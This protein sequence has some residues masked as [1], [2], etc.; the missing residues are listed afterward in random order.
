MLKKQPQERMQTAF[1]VAHRQ[2]DVE[3]ILEPEDLA[4]QEVRANPRSPP[5]PG[6]ARAL[7][8]RPHAWRLPPTSPPPCRLSAS[9]P[10]AH[11]Q[12]MD[13]QTA[14]AVRLYIFTL[15]PAVQAAMEALV[16]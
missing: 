7:P 12:A 2:L 10:S 6:S 16:A 13:D 14:K 4:T 9:A 15:M 1:D 5:L 11:V 3:P 8:F